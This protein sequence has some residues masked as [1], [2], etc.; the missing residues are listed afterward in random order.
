M[1][2][3]TKTNK[4][5]GVIK[6]GNNPNKNHHT[7]HIKNFKEEIEK[8]N[9]GEDL[10]NNSVLKKGTAYGVNTNHKRPNLSKP[11]AVAPQESQPKVKQIHPQQALNERNAKNGKTKEFQEKAKQTF[12]Q[13]ELSKKGASKGNAQG[14]D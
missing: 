13:Q 10:D 1:S 8:I 5:H 6:V 3:N 12:A 11:I 14:R 2:K 9:N 4:K 7:D